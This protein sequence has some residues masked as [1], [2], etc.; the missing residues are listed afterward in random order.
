MKKAKKAFIGVIS[1]II[2]IAVQGS[3][4]AQADTAQNAL[5][6]SLVCAADKG[7][8]SVYPE[9]SAAAVRAAFNMGVKIVCVNIRRTKDGVLIA[10]EDESADRTLIT[11]DGKD[12]TGKISEL[13]YD[14]INACF[15]KNNDFTVSE[16]KAPTLGEVISLVG[17]GQ[18]IMIKNAWEHKDALTAFDAESKN[19][20]ILRL[21]ASQKELSKW[22]GDNPDAPTVCAVYTG[23]IIFPA[24][25]AARLM[26]NK[27]VIEY[28]SRNVNSIVFSEFLGEKVSK[29]TPMAANVTNYRLCGGRIDDSVGYDELVTAGY[30][31]IITQRP[32]SLVNYISDVEKAKAVLS[33]TIAR[34][35][36]K[37]DN[38]NCT[39]DSKKKL[40]WAIEASYDARSLSEIDIAANNIKAAQDR[41]VYIKGDGSFATPTRVI[42]VIAVGAIFVFADIFF[43]AQPRKKRMQKSSKK[44]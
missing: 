10:M 43:Y 41:L 39:G 9:C 32:S 11:S 7:D 42:I 8:F 1:A 19:R 30:N 5:G 23:S 14:E 24:L 31:I 3:A 12:V 44:K 6:G 27:G 36:Y 16:Y 20:L 4:F 17:D 13:S 25:S 21:E 33:E 38:D 28:N 15:L 2:C 22:L 29:T 35:Q 40:M 34:A 26:E 18:Y 37:Y